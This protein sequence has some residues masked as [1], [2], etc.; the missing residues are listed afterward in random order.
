MSERCPDAVKA[1]D[2]RDPRTRKVIYKCKTQCSKCHGTG[3]VEP[4]P[5]CGGAGLRPGGFP[6]NTCGT[7]GKV[8]SFSSVKTT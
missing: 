2:G 6:C 8:P 7:C 1:Y 4:C 5:D 3:R